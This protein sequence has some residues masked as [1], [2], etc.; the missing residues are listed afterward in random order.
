M[1]QGLVEF[2]GFLLIFTVLLL[3]FNLILIVLKLN[4]HLCTKT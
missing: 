4:A 2:P 3:T 1:K